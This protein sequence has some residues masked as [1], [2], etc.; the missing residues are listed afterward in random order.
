MVAATEE[1][2]VE[3]FRANGGITP[4]R[5]VFRDEIGI[6]FFPGMVGLIPTRLCLA[7]QARIRTKGP[8]SDLGV[9]DRASPSRLAEEAR[10]PSRQRVA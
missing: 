9:S 5:R 1:G 7:C 3:S 8:L 10:S 2:R 4:A 6:S